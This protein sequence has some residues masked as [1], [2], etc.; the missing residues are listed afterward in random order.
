MNSTTSAT[1]AQLNA[2]PGQAERVSRRAIGCGAKASSPRCWRYPRRPRRSRAGLSIQR[3]CGAHHGATLAR[4]AH[5]AIR[6]G[7]VIRRD[8][9]MALEHGQD[10]ANKGHLSE[11]LRNAIGDEIS[12]LKGL[13]IKI[14]FERAFLTRLTYAFQNALRTLVASAFTHVTNGVFTSKP[15]QTDSAVHRSA[16]RPR[17][18]GKP[19]GPPSS[20]RAAHRA[21]FRRDTRRAP[22]RVPPS[23]ALLARA[24]SADPDQPR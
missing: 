15:R 11:S 1:C 23:R 3:R 6:I 10:R 21:R 13:W 20:N 9:N 2:R 12:R 7:G 18:A 8:F 4:A 17:R 22:H 14:E 19:A 5:P 24:D 16:A